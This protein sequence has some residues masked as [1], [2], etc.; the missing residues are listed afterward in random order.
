M[1]P[2]NRG[3][4]GPNRLSGAGLGQGGVGWCIQ[5]HPRMKPISK[6]AFYCCGIRMEDAESER[7]ICGDTYARLFMN[8]EGLRIL[9][10]FKREVRP[11]AG[12]VT[13]HRIVD[14]I[15]RRELALDP[16]LLVVIVGAG[17]DSRAYRLQG[18]T[19]AELDEPPVIAHK[20][21][22]LPASD[23][24][25]TLHRI[26]IDF[27]LESLT[28]KLAPFARRERVIVVIEGVLHYL[29]EA[30][31]RELLGCLR[32]TFPRHE[33]VCDLM[34]RRFFERY[35][36][37]VHEK[38]ADLGA[39]FRYTVDCPEGIFLGSGYRQRD[40]HSIVARTVELAAMGPSADRRAWIPRALARLFFRTA[41]TGYSIFELE[42][43]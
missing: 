21:A 23:C 25:N 42:L 34:S 39:T 24:P 9:G 15:L 43:G 30:Q 7:P 16:G 32:A 17:F 38:I 18:G 37:T 4:R 26:A 31:I 20:D 2:T 27:S 14:D 35:A 5:T 1:M 10:A 41:L 8:E 11:K 6:T 13:R 19:W 29:E 12:N 3:M 40:R 22:R 28:Q 36:R 33:L